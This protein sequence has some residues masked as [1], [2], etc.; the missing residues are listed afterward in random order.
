M[1]IIIN[2]AILKL[3]RSDWVKGVFDWALVVVDQM[4][5]KSGVSIGH[6]HSGQSPPDSATTKAQ[7]HLSHAV[8]S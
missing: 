8:Y 4:H 6:Q 5:L 2:L 3:T 7:A 1:C